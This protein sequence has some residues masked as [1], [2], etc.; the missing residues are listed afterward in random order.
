MR[1][2]KKRRSTEYVTD[3]KRD[4]IGVNDTFENQVYLDFQDTPV[5]EWQLT[6]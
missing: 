2:I 3:I 1:G 5:I 4:C 6:L